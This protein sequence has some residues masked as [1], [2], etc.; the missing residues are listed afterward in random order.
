MLSVALVS[1]VG[2]SRTSWIDLSN[3]GEG[4]RDD[5]SSSSAAFLGRLDI[6][7]DSFCKTV[8]N[9]DQEYVSSA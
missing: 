3:E 7:S 6:N 8:G 2:S 4:D 1:M 9:S 5:G